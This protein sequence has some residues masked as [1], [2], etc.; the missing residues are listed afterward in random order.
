MEHSIWWLLF[1]MA[2][3]VG[4]FFSLLIFTRPEKPRRGTV[5][6][7][8]LVLIFS[9]TLI[10]YVLHWSGN[11]RSFPHLAGLWQACNYLYGPLLL[12]FFW[13]EEKTAGQWKL[14]HFLPFLFLLALWLPF[15]LLPAGEKLDWLQQ[16][17]PYQTALLPHD[18]FLLLLHP[19][20]MIGSQML[21][22]GFFI[23]HSRKENS[24]HKAFKRLIALLFA[25]FVGANAT[26]F[27]LVQTPYFTLLWDYLI[28]LAMTLCIFRLGLLAFHQPAYL[29]LPKTTP[30]EKYTTSSLSNA[31]SKDLANRIR[32]LIENEEKYLESDL[33][34]SWVADE[35]NASPQY[36][37]Q[38]I[39]EHF[40]RSFSHWINRYRIE[41]ACKLLQEGASAK[42]A[43]YQS[44]FN[45][46]STFYQVF[47]KEK[48]LPPA[49]YRQIT[50]EDF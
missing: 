43:G 38:A 24:D 41:Y 30:H 19:A 2:A 36:V 7:G 48:G 46:L 8:V 22:A 15:G 44:G 16:D 4:I 20:V 50:L 35:L 5:A 33:R 39:N 14:W 13:P 32:R 28:S 18:I 12:F 25:V 17:T 47:K 6:L 42:E 34:L 23:Y 45:N 27:I 10:Q 11:F 31:Q 9:F 26:Y 1:A 21:Y 37:S 49:A 3:G 29:F 40:G